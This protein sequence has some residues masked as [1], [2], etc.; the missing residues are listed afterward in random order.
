MVARA[1]TEVTSKLDSLKLVI[2]I[3]LLVAG[4]AQFY[5][6]EG[7]SLLYRVLALLGFVFVALGFV[8][9]TRMGYG[10]WQ[11]ARD[12]R[13]EVRKVVW[14]TRQETV[15][16]TLLVIVVVILVG[17]MLWLMDMFLRWAV[18]FLTGQ[19]G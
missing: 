16:T 2:A 13:T 18:F 11:F 6:F 9:M 5:Y 8:Y 3:L 14:P 12:A 15:Q 19:G 4:I 10:V 17:L 7:E 1:E